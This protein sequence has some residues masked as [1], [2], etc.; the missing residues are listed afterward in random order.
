M[1]MESNL[2]RDEAVGSRYLRPMTPATDAPMVPSRP[3]LHMK[4]THGVNVV[5]TRRNR[6][7]AVALYWCEPQ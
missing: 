5:S 3:M 2:N 1:T 7:I 4:Y 6:R